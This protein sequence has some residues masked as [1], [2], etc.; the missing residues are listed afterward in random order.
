MAVFK[1]GKLCEVYR[2]E[3]GLE[4]LVISHAERRK[5]LSTRLLG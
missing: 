3:T 5:T 4:R 2:V 1:D